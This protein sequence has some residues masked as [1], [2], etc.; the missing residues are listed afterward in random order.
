MSGADLSEMR[1]IPSSAEGA[2][3]ALWLNEVAGARLTGCSAISPL[4]RRRS[5]P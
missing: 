1:A 5:F 4:Q 3:Y 2:G